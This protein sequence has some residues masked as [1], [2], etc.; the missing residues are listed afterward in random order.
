MS[1]PTYFSGASGVN[2]LVMPDGV[3]VAAQPNPANPP[4]GQGI[5]GDGC[6][7]NCGPVSNALDQTCKVYRPFDSAYTT[8]L[9]TG[10]A[11]HL[12][13][14]FFRGGDS[15]SN[16]SWTHYLDVAAGADIIDA[17]TRTSGTNQLNYADGDGIQ[18]TQDSIAV[19]FVVVF[20]ARE[21]A[22]GFRRIYLMRD[23]SGANCA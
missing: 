9:H 17:A 6:G 18:I 15:L 14:D 19:G 12:T 11:C 5:S 21:N 4:D 10:V 7:D 20:S 22:N 23:T 8:P 2:A 13:P 1:S 16:F 3:R